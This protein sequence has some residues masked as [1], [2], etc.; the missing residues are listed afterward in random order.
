M[1]SL[2]W[3]SCFWV[4]GWCVSGGSGLVLESSDDAQTSVACMSLYFSWSLKCLRNVVPDQHK[5]TT[6]LTSKLSSGLITLYGLSDYT[7]LLCVH[8]ESLHQDVW[9]VKMNIILWFNHFFCIWNLWRL[10]LKT[11]IPA[12]FCLVSCRW[13]TGGYAGAFLPCFY[14]PNTL[15]LFRLFLSY[16]SVWGHP[17]FRLSHDQQD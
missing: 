4:V 9:W 3:I 2:W 1:A 17:S 14:D 7:F 8:F 10:C 6:G 5:G 15:L 13:I 16:H 12:A 11:V